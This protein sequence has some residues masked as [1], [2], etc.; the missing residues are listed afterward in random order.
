MGKI[1]LLP[2]EI[3]NRIAAGEVIE[4]PA[5]VVKELIE[6][7]LDANADELKIIIKNAGKKEITVSDNGE[8]MTEEDVTLA[9][10]KH[11]TSKI[12][13]VEDL[14]N[15]K[16]FGFRGEA[17]SSIVSVAIV[18]IIT[19]TSN[20]DA[21]VKLLVEDAGRKIKKT[22]IPTKTGTTVK[23]LHLFYNT[24]ARLKFLK[25]NNTELKYI[26]DTITAIALSNPD[27]KFELIVD[28]Q[29]DL[30]F[31]KQETVLDRICEIYGAELKETLIYFES[32]DDFLKV[33]GYISKPAINRPT[34]NVQYLFLNKRPIIAKYFNFWISEAFKELVPKGRYPYAFVYIDASSEFVDVNVHPAKK[35]VR[36]LNEFFIGNKIINTI[37]SVLSPQTAIPEIPHIEPKKSENKKEI[38][39]SI[40]NAIYKFVQTQ[41]KK[42][43]PVV[44]P[45]EPVS[46]KE[47][48]TENFFTLFNTY[49]F[50]EKNE[51]EVL[52]IDQHAAHERVIYERLKYE[53]KKKE[54]LTQNLLIPLNVSLSPSEMEVLK[55]TEDILK[56]IGF[57]F[58]E[59][60]QNTIAIYG[61]PSYIR[62]TDD[63]SLFLDI[64]SL[65]M[66]NK[67]VDTIT[68]KEEI[69]KTIACKSAVKA[70]DY[71]NK[72]QKEVLIKQLLDVESKYTCPHGRPAIIKLSKKEIEK[73]FSRT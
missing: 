72:E 50:Y 48:K 41:E 61:V 19:K 43:Q 65:L 22:Y 68:L 15:I 1:V 28:A 6:N 25:S 62:H 26:K 29:K 30:T 17:L 27:I 57:V 73:W 59:F 35:E 11:S 8:G 14:N 34:R 4:N 49:I 45:V 7:S 5:S 16:T 54:N 31:Y 37:K 13:T 60:G 36:F 55:S 10:K 24:P 40:Q 21:G 23:V 32:G 52:V 3:Y 39:E 20:M 53:I 71:L 51:N 12:K 44:T 33:K 70:G 67:K 46:F 47:F 2:P 9:I 66:D 64:I 56:E 18:E 58:E 69:L 38:K 42:K 63:K